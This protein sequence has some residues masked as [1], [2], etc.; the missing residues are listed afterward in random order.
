MEVVLPSRRGTDECTFAW[1]G[2]YHRLSKDYQFLPITE[3]DLIYLAMT[4]L[5]LRRLCR[6]AR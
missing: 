1:L 6:A 2:N 5:M 3:A 4:R